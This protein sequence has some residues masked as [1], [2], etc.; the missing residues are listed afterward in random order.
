MTKEKKVVNVKLVSFGFKYG[1]PHSNYYFDVGF[2]KNPARQKKWGFFSDAS[3]EM[4]EFV[5]N[6]EQAKFFVEMVV[7]LIEFLSQI[8]QNQVFAFG[9]SA[10]RHRS[11]IITEAIA[12]MLS[13]RGIQV[14]VEHRD[15]EQ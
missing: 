13:D 11:F 7:P 1:Y 5:M 3:K 2:I 12:K 8:D 10:G 15:L 6:Q 14:N 4:Y 9:C